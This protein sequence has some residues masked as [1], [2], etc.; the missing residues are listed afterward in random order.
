MLASSGS[1][2]LLKSEGSLII[3]CLLGWLPGFHEFSRDV[4]SEQVSHYL[5]DL[6]HL[7]FPSTFAS[8]LLRWPRSVQVFLVKVPGQIRTELHVPGIIPFGV[9][10]ITYSFYLIL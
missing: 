7:C 5:A 8:S 6:Q 10:V 3:D 4:S 1:N 9:V 2:C